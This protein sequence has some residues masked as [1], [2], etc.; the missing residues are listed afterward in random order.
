MKEKKRIMLDLRRGNYT[1]L[2]GLAR[3]HKVDLQTIRSYRQ[4]IIKSHRK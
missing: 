2:R 1:S 3:K 4:K